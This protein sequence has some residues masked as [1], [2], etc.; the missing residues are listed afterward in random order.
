MRH[1]LAVAAFVGLTFA[2]VTAQTLSD[3]RE[4]SRDDGEWAEEGRSL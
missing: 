2:S 1:A 4:A 3:E